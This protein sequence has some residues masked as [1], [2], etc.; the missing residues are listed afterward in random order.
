VHPVLS[1]L[2]KAAL[3]RL[4]VVL[5]V[6]SRSLA[7]ASQGLGG[8]A[9]GLDS[10]A[11]SSEDPEPGPSEPCGPPNSRQPIR[12][13][14]ELG[15][16]PPAHW[17]ELVRKHAPELLRPGMLASKPVPPRCQ[18]QRLTQESV[19][20]QRSAGAQP[21]ES[22]GPVRS[23][24]QAEHCPDAAG[25]DRISARS[26]LGASEQTKREHT[27]TREL[28]P[29]A[30]AA[31]I[32][33]H[34]AFD[35]AHTLEGPPT[36]PSSSVD[37]EPPQGWKAGW[38]FGIDSAY[39][40]VSLVSAPRD[41]SE[42][43]RAPMLDTELDR[44]LETGPER[45]SRSTEARAS[46]SFADATLVEQIGSTRERS[47]TQAQRIPR[48]VAAHG[49]RY[50]THRRASR[51]RFSTHSDA[52]ASPESV[53]EQIAPSNSVERLEHDGAISDLV[54]THHADP[55]RESELEALLQHVLS[56]RQAEA[57]WPGLPG[58]PEELGRRPDPAESNRW[59]ELPGGL[60]APSMRTRFQ[61]SRGW[62]DDIHDIESR[63]RLDREQQG[64]PWNG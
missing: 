3:R 61:S 53:N 2:K 12:F 30:S 10:T 35:T 22:S 28:R 43:R 38:P 20:A 41:A 27:R 24:M 52:Q 47:G 59:P 7:A 18:T 56:E 39:C 13:S 33:R 4:A 25:P 19:A 44:S 29:H 54:R 26:H 17:V 51:G 8:I 31:Q 21:Y 6:W 42:S 57:L 1:N 34:D 14:P 48:G 46:S 58:E 50:S 5:N 16:G 64:L 11:A 63:R 32:G 40:S 49:R 55:A 9:D 37:V 15:G 62:H 60:S 36:E 45:A 23:E